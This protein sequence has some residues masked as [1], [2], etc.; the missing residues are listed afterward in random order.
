[1]RKVFTAIIIVIVITVFV[2]MGCEIALDKYSYEFLGTF[3]TMIQFVGYAKNEKEFK[4][5]AQ[6]GQKRFEELHRLFDIY[7]EYQ[8]INN[9]KTINDKAGIEPVV[10]Q[11][12]ILDVISF[13]IKWYEKTDGAVNIALG[14]VLSI[15]H[16]Y[17]EEGLSEPQNAR[18]PDIEMLRQ[19]FLKSDI[20]KIIIDREKKIVFLQ[21]EG[22]KLDLGAVAKGYATE[23]VAAEL[24]EQGYDSFMISGG[25]NVRIAGAPADGIRTKWNIG[26]QDPD[27]NEYIPDSVLLDTAYVSDTSVVTSGDYQRYYVVDNKRIHHLIDPVTLMPAEHYRAVT[28][29]TKDSGVADF[30][31][32][33]VF[34]LPYDKSRSLVEG[35]DGVDA[36]WVMSD[37][38]IE[39]T[40]NMRKALKELGGA[41]NR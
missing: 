26:I 9:M 40:E 36:L 35:L 3:D 14:P 22:M 8:G 28:I 6:K 16:D 25:G 21:E 38:E 24:I 39:A 29:I 32:T 18:I 41:T 20:D 30:L 27:G 10:V 4:D 19:A 31:S 34:L 12:E 13:S 11:K 5:M 33:A 23:I 15:W 37:G 7:H 2:C 17:R 1:V